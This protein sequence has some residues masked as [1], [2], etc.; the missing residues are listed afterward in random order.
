MIWKLICLCYVWLLLKQTASLTHKLMRVDR[1]VFG[2]LEQYQYQDA[3]MQDHPSSNMTIY[4]EP[5]ILAK[6]W[7]TS[8]TPWKHSNWIYRV[9]E[10]HS[11][12]PNI[13]SDHKYDPSTDNTTSWNIQHSDDQPISDILGK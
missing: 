13:L 6:T 2:S 9:T 3:W 4:H 1:T 12:D 5:G 11:Y 7:P 10:I 8:W